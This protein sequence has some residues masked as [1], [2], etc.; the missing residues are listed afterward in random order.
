MESQAIH[1]DRRTGMQA[2]HEGR[3]H[4]GPGLGMGV[5]SERVKRRDGEARMV[6][7]AMAG[8]IALGQRTATARGGVVMV[9]PTEVDELLPI[10]GG[11]TVRAKHGGEWHSPA[12]VPPTC[13]RLRERRLR[14]R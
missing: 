4:D 9:K 5:A 7:R 13:Q 6:D 10:S 1:R 11:C 14:G 2:T 8:S 3:S 12:P